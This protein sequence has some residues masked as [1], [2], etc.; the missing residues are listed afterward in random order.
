MRVSL[1]RV[2]GVLILLLATGGACSIADAA[3]NCPAS[4]LTYATHFRVSYAHVLASALD[5]TLVSTSGDTTRMGFD[6]ATSHLS[7]NAV[8]GVWAGE[9]VLERIDV[10]AVP[11]GTVVP[12]I[13]FLS[14]NG[15]VFSA[16]GVGGGD[17]I[18]T[19]TLAGMADSV[20]TDA[21]VP[22][23]CYGCTRQ[24]NT[25]LTLPVSI[26][27]GTPVDVAFDLLY[28]DTP[29]GYGYATVVGAY[30]V[31]GLPD[32]VRAVECSA[33]DVTPS[34]RESWGKLKATYR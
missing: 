31:S 8:G 10:T 32:G 1:R 27:A 26:T 6:R 33:S 23:P 21:T 2:V 25:I 9:R 7:L 28:H 22:G 14:L 29:A 30:G 4:V 24:V 34:R 15:E 12:A 19:A 5:T 13:V 20:L 11:P 18:F 16:G 3:Q 17:A